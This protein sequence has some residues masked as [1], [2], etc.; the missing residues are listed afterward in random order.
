[1]SLSATLANALSGLNVAQQALSVTANNV[2]NAN[3]PGYSRKVLNQEAVV[4]SERGAGVRSTD[5]ARITDAFLTEEIR[6]QSSIAGQSEAVRRYQDLLQLA[7]GAPGDSRDLAVQ[8]G[9]LQVALDALATSPET[10]AAGLQLLSA[11]DEVARVI[12]GLAGQVQALRGDADQ[13]IG[14]TVAAINAEIEAIDDLNDEIQRLAHLG[15]INPELLDR[16]D[17]LIRSLAEKIDVRTYTQG[18]GT[19]ALYTAGGE[20]LLDSTPRVLVYDPANLVAQDTSFDPIAI[21]RPT[22]LDP[23]S[24]Q[25]LDPSAGVTLVSGGVRA[26]LTPELQNDTLADADQQ[27]TSRV[28]SGRLAGLL[29]IRDRTLPDLDDQ[30]QELAAGLRFALNAA[31]ND[32]TPVPPPAE[33]SGSRTDLSDFAAATRSGSATFAVIDTTDGST[34]LAF[35]IDVGAVADETALAAQIDAAL[36]AF[37]SAAIGADGNLEIALAGSGQGIAIAGGDSSIRVADAA[38]RDRDYGLAHYFGLNDLLVDDGARPS[39][40]AVRADIAA[41]PALLGTARLDVAAGPPLVATLGG[42]GDNRGAQALAD[43][44]AAMQPMIARGGLSARSV[45][46]ATYAGD[47]IAHSAVLAQ[48][49]ERAAIRDRALADQLEY[50]AAAVSGVN[51]DEEMA[52][53]VQLQQA[54]SVAARM[55]AVTDELFDELLGLAR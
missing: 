10:S 34:L 18:N 12:G 43:A 14:R 17:A 9:G 49:A 51:L 26:A 54:Y 21:F 28:R 23:A 13:E 36:G 55:I 46:L 40:F 24:G 6:R 30:L 27:I 42:D 50:R 33:L 3:T 20:T 1:M 8:I 45:T 41:D 44:L 32:A 15:Q 39:E 25:P 53:M 37:G 4:L 29:E 16:R 22:Q 52:R 19:L 5:I 2:A 48:S 47:I 7:F 31:H 11:I 35:Q 38:G